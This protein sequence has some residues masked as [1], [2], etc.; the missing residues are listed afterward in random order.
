VPRNKI[1]MMKVRFVQLGDC[2]MA[3]ASYYSKLG[4]FWRKFRGKRNN[5]GLFC[6]YGGLLER[7]ANVLEKIIGGRQGK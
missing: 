1:A 7:C 2:N 6:V 5:Y 4:I 3:T